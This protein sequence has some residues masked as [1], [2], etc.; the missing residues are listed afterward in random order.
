V[1]PPQS[2]G[3]P[4][5]VSPGVHAPSPHTIGHGPQSAAQ[6][7]QLSKGNVQMKS[8]QSAHE[9]SLRQRSH[10]SRGSHTPSALQAVRSQL[11]LKQPSPP[12][13]TASRT[14]AFPA[15][16][17]ASLR[18][19]IGASSVPVRAHARNATRRDATRRD[20]RSAPGRVGRAGSE[21]V[22]LP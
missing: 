15:K 22:K 1:Q 20:A 13:P 14:S 9:Q 19:L 7:E 18:V 21:D 16:K 11:Q 17:G 8:P 4:A 3:Q 5:H 2:A 12:A 6:A 10:V